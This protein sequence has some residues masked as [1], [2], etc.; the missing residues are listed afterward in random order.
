[1]RCMVNIAVCLLAIL[2]TQMSWSQGCSD[3]GI[4]TIG[5]LNSDVTKDS[6]SAIDFTEADMD[7]LLNATIASEKWRFE[8]ATAYSRGQSGI[9]IYQT[10]VKSSMRIREKMQLNLK[11]PYTMYFGELGNVNGLGDLT[12][13][14]QNTI[15][16]GKNKRFAY[17]VAVVVPT[18]RADLQKD[19]FALP[20][21]YQTTL[22]S[23]NSVIGFSAAIKTWSFSL[24]YQ[25]S[26]GKNNNAFDPRGITLDPNDPNYNDLNEERLGYAPGINLERGSDLAFRAEKRF[27]IKKRWSAVVGVL[28]LYRLQKSRVT[29]L[30]GNTVALDNTEGLTLNFTGGS[31]FE[32]NKNWVF[33]AN[34]GI[35]TIQ[36]SVMADGL[37]RKFVGILSLAYRI[38]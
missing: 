31:R 26:F 10:V 4:C 1:M 13:S 15:F 2:G 27:K 6:V 21:A 3:P 5:A 7:A 29:G 20:M 19:G 36:R 16:S 24:G 14:L 18:G 22:G 30:D 9:D 8:L 38:W 34:V 33:R 11:L 25:H 35:P 28:P 23:F 17:T 12:L 37:K 32:I